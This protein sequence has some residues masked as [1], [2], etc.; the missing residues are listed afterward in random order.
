MC[1]G[2]I[3]P[4][5]VLSNNRQVIENIPI[6]DRARNVS[7]LDLSQTTL[8]VERALGVHWCVVNDTLSFR[9]I[10][11]DRPFIRRGILSTI[12]AIYDHLGLASPFLLAGKKLLQRLCGA[13]LDWDDEI[14]SEDRVL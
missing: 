2:R 5:K 1:C 10:L 6:V 4:D 7:N 13:Q 11:K 9:I 3:P 8:P 14:S 12:S